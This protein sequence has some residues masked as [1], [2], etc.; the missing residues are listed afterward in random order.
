M[1]QCI[2]SANLD[3]YDPSVKGQSFLY[4]AWYPAIDCR[5]SQVQFCFTCN[6]K[7]RVDSYA[8]VHMLWT[9][10]H[11]CWVNNAGNVLLHIT[12]NHLHSPWR[13]NGMSEGSS[14]DNSRGGWSYNKNLEQN[15]ETPKQNK[16]GSHTHNID[17]DTEI[18]ANFITCIMERL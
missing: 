16:T 6:S 3:R 13:Y 8:F 17:S 18:I 1:N 5:L 12:C 10:F 9:K 14:R 15:G 2:I 7:R 4:N 11:S